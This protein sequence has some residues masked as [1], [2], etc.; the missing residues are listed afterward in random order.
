[1]A[2]NTEKQSGGRMYLVAGILFPLIIGLII[3][4]VVMVNNFPNDEPAIIFLRFL[5]YIIC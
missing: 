4:Q 5:S 2:K 3:A 1:M